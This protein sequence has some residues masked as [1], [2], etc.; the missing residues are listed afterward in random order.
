M[1]PI[2]EVKN[3]SKKYFIGHES[4]VAGYHT[5]RDTLTDFV[6]RPFSFLNGQG[7]EEFW[8]LQ[9]INFSVRPG[10]AVGI[11]GHNGAGKTTLLKILAKITSPTGGE[12]SLRGRVSSML[13]VGTGFHPELTGRENIYLNGAML[14]M[15][16][17]EIDEKFS[18]IIEFAG[19][20]KFLD[21]PLKRFSSGMN[22]RLAFAVAAHLEPEI[23]LIDEVLAVGDAEFQR[24]SLTK[25]DEITRRQGRT[26]IFVSHN[27]TAV[28]NL[29]SRCLVIREGRIIFDGNP[30]EAIHLYTKQALLDFK[31]EW[32]GEIGDEDVKLVHAWVRSLDPTGHFH[33]AAPIEV[34]GELEILKPVNNLIFGFN[35]HSEFGYELAYVLYDDDK[36]SIS[37]TIAPGRLKKR[38]IIPANT[39]THGVYKIEF[40]VGIHMTKKIAKQELIF[41][42]DNIDGLG[43]R[44]PV[45]SHKGITSLFRPLWTVKD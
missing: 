37:Q 19:V 22:L 38:F 43:R 23:L 33:T 5:L 14:G 9:D 20:E 17:K 12:V 6:R 8:A 29:C 32:R 16:K 21:T 31:N 3:L 28:A 15:T 7:R 11:I 10:E 35:L 4:T 2:I 36:D 41:S 30:Q 45:T 26:V 27:L 24:R 44:F 13:E 25:M 39:L 18:D 40:D 34:S 42:L 1:E